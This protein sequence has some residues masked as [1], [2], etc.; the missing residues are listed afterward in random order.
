MDNPS[1]TPPTGAV[2]IP[3]PQDPHEAFRWGR[4]AD[5]I[6]GL[7]REWAQ[8]QRSG[9][10]FDELLIA[11]ENTERYTDGLAFLHQLSTQ[12]MASLYWQGRFHLA[13]KQWS[14]A[15]AAL[16]QSWMIDPWP[17]TALLRVEAVSRG[18]N[19]H[20]LTI[21]EKRQSVEYWVNAIEGTLLR[22]IQEETP[23]PGLV[24]SLVIR[25]ERAQAELGPMVRDAVHALFRRYANRLADE[26]R[27]VNAFLPWWEEWADSLSTVGANQEVADHAATL[28]NALL[29]AHLPMHLLG[30]LSAAELHTKL[31]LDEAAAS[32][33]MEDWERA[34]R[35]YEG[36][37]NHP[38][39]D[40]PHPWGVWW[41]LACGHL[42]LGQTDKAREWHQRLVQVVATEINDEEAGVY[43]ENIRV[44]MQPFV[45]ALGSALDGANVEPDTL[46]YW[47][48][49][50]DGTPEFRSGA[51]ATE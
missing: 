16:T 28:R 18:R 6:P 12:D 49:E 44:A 27:W 11:Y 47:R 30:W 8:G 34:V 31:W 25:L 15:Q 1:N 10:T 21:P 14:Q 46:H 9:K 38:W 26:P 17:D 3:L 39:T 4:F 37:V 19:W 40:A 33:R 22:A 5:A 45:E 36:W 2:V 48:T 41:N 50:A 13:L 23:S 24:V 43:V 32:L 20:L 51:I 7:E 42:I 29:R 35:C